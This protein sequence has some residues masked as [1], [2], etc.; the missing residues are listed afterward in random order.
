MKKLI[1]SLTLLFTLVGSSHAAFDFLT[2]FNVGSRFDNGKWVTDFVKNRRDD[3]SPFVVRFQWGIPTH[4]VNGDALTIQEIKEYRIYQGKHPDQQKL[5]ATVTGA[6]NLSV[7][8]ELK[9]EIGYF[10]ITTVDVD[11]SESEKSPLIA[12]NTRFP[13]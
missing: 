10:S 5:I 12:L 8:V 1:L 2:D 4:R 3:V 13:G 7:Q 11:D 6:T 9:D